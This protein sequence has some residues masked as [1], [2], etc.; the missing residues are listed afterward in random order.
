MNNDKEMRELTRMYVKWLG[1]DFSMNIECDYNSMSVIGLK[2]DLNWRR[3]F[4][5]LA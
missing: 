3:S 5:C 2:I 4:C 1:W